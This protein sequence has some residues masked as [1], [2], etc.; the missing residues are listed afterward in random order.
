MSTDD[1]NSLD[2]TNSP[3][4]MQVETSFDDPTADVILRTSDHVDFRVH[5]AV[6]PLAS[7]AFRDMF[8][9]FVN[10]FEEIKSDGALSLP[11]N[12]PSAKN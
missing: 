12:K 8:V 11:L 5:R 9:L 3:P 4:I 6:L 7:P 10:I 2:T 1:T